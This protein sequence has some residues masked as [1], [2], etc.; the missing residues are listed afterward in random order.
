[1]KTGINSQYI[2]HSLYDW[3]H[4]N[5]QQDCIVQSPNSL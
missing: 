5:K 4:P 2:K 1:M 3:D